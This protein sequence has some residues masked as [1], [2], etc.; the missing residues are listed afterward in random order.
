MKARLLLIPAMVL[1]M[2]TLAQADVAGQVQVKMK[3]DT[4]CTVN[5]TQSSGTINHFGELNFGT[6]DATWSNIL[7]SQVNT[8]VNGGELA[9]T[10]G[11]DNT[12]FKVSIDGG[13]RGNRTMK[14]TTGNDT[15]AYNVYRDASHNMPFVINTPE[16]YTTAQAST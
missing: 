16:I 4:G 13:E 8:G 5:N 3:I 6:A 2:C 15:I 14:L 11:K 7:T 9:V 10:C 1:G 12:P